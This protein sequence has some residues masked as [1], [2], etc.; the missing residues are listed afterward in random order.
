MTRQNTK[1]PRTGRP[2]KLHSIIER[3]EHGRP[4]TAG[5][6]VIAMVR[7]VWVPWEDAAASTGVSARTIRDWRRLGATARE[8]IA[9]HNPADPHATPISQ[10][11]RDL[12]QFVTDLEQAEATVHAAHLGVITNASKGGLVET[13]TVETAVAGKVTTKVTTTIVKPPVWQA[14]AWMLQSRRPDQY[15]RRFEFTGANGAPLLPEERADRLGQ[16]MEAYLT[17]ADDAKTPAEPAPAPAA[18]PEE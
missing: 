4:I 14:S 10:N 8:R 18:A 17:G 7:S 2:L 12:A 15:R 6:K 3:D 11:E 9:N 13:R 5:E 16:M 1:T